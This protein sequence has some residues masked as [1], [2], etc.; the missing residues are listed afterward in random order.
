MTRHRV[1]FAELGQLDKS[2]YLIY[3]V[4][5]RKSQIGGIYIVAK[6]Y[7]I[8]AHHSKKAQQSAEKF[9]VEIQ[10]VHKARSPSVIKIPEGFP[11]TVVLSA[12]E[13]GQDESYNQRR[14]KL[15]DEIVSEDPGV[16]VF[17]A[18]GRDKIME[19]VCLILSHSPLASLYIY[20]YERAK[21]PILQDARK[22]VALANLD[23]HMNAV[24]VYDYLWCRS[25]EL[26]YPPEEEKGMDE[27]CST[28]AD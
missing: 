28:P 3:T 8:V 1:I 12:P 25:M 17:L 21:P 7:V 22:G 10:K 18:Q 6:P 9:A 13:Y 2:L 20:I 15:I 11:K 4:L 26:P 19:H 16:V 27:V 23:E 14:T 5:S 24:A